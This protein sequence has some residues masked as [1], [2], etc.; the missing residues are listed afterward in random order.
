MKHNLTDMLSKISGVKEEETKK[1]FEEVKKNQK[2]LNS[3]SCHNF[4][5]I[6]IDSIYKNERYKCNICGGKMNF[7]DIHMYML[8][9]VAAGG[10]EEDVYILK[11]RT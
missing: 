4:G 1:I 9:Y 8:G 10:K 3:C 5:E 6:D 11:K 2:R 7:H